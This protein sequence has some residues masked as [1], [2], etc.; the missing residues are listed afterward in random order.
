MSAMTFLS[1]MTLVIVRVAGRQ[2]EWV[3]ADVSTPKEP[4]PPRREPLG[5][6]PR[7]QRGARAAPDL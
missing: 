2:A 3:G 5:A 7:V 6:G 4:V 1:V